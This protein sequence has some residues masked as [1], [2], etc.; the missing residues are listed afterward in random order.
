MNFSDRVAVVESKPHLFNI[1]KSVLEYSDAAINLRQT[2]QQCLQ[3]LD[4]SI[5]LVD[6]LFEDMDG[7]SLIEEI[8]LKNRKVPIVGFVCQT[9]IDSLDIEEQTIRMMAE[10]SGVNA[11]FLAPFNLGEVV[12]TINRLLHVNESAAIA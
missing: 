10:Q 8:R 4:S 9:Q 5:I 6:L 1:L 7:L 12:N 2:A 11:F 3:N